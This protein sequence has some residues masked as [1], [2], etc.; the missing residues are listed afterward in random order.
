MV[1]GAARPLANEVT[2]GRMAPL[3][4]TPPLAPGVEAP[5][6]VAGSKM[7]TALYGDP[8][9]IP[10][11]LVGVMRP[12]LVTR[13]A[14]LEAREVTVGRP[15]PGVEAPIAV[16]GSKMIT[17]LYGDAVGMPATLVGVMRPVLVRREARL[18][19]NEV[20]VGRTAPGVEAPIAVAG[21][22]TMTALYGDP[23][24]IPAALVG[25]T[26]PVVVMADTRLGAKEVT[27]G[28]PT[29]GVEAPAAVEGT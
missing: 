16:A 14:R 27:V 6:A 18:G 25:V 23:V 10:A 3:P 7:I 28:R 2:V 22:K 20:N 8:V 24:G 1:V 13:E 17:A 11:A 19:A 21:S 26:R 9:G 4:G 12:V 15:A 29:P 5:M